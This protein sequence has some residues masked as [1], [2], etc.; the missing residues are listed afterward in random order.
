MF[1]K[2]A[3][4]AISTARANYNGNYIYLG[5][6]ARGEYRY[7]TMP[8]DSLAPNAWGLHHVHGN[9]WEWTEDCWNDSNIGNPGDGSARSA[10]DCSRHVVRGGS[11][12]N[13]PSWLRAARRHWFSTVMRNSVVGF[14]IARPLRS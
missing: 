3:A 7:R 11:F 8:V 9:V 2:E 14:R 5:G 6:G 10:P 1:R 13:I 4:E 12:Y